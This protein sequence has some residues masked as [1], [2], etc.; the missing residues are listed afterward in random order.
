[1]TRYTWIYASHLPDI[2]G[3][4]GLT[5][6]WLRMGTEPCS[7]VMIRHQSEN[8]AQAQSGMFRLAYQ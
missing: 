5:Q 6:P 8:D 3:L 7:R 1:M 4:R 2:M